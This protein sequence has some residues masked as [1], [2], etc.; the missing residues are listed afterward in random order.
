MIY[1]K[2]IKTLVSDALAEDIGSGDITAELIPENKIAKARVMTRGD[3]IVC[4]QVFVDEVFNQVDENIEIKW[5][6]AECEAVKAGKILFWV[7]G[8]ARSLLT[9]ERTALNFLQMLSGTATLTHC[10]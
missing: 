4:G 6:V 8:K 3:M 2:L 5:E 10:G 1:S 7:T 9:A